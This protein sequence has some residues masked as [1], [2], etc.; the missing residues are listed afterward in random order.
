MRLATDSGLSQEQRQLLSVP[1]GIV[2]EVCN[3]FG[4]KMLEGG[5][6][7]HTLLGSSWR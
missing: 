2:N 6:I 5:R 1:C 3:S 4:L 7:V